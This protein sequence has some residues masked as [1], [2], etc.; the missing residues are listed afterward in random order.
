[1]LAQNGPKLQDFKSCAKLRESCA[2]LHFFPIIAF[3][4]VMWLFQHVRIGNLY[5]FFP[6]FHSD[7]PISRL[8]AQNSV[9]TRPVKANAHTCIH[10]EHHS[11][12]TWRQRDPLGNPKK[13]AW[14][15]TATGWATACCD[16][17]S[18]CQISTRAQFLV[19]FVIYLRILDF[20]NETPRYGNKHDEWFFRYIWPL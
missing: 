4:G 2:A 19:D 16:F 10:L 14:P 3:F 5:D 11:G 20:H 15:P 17:F 7:C 8:S 6:E 1:M 12:R 18:N 13:V 9:K